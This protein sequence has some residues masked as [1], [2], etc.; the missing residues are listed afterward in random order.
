VLEILRAQDVEFDVIDYLN[1]P[2]SRADLERLLDLLPE[3]PAILVR[4]DKQFQVLG[5]TESDYLTRTTVIDLLLQHPQLMQ[6]PIVVRGNRALI[7]RP[8][9]KVNELLG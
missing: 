5:L 3:A 4:H 1:T 8:V 2:P 6:R 7:T 9:E